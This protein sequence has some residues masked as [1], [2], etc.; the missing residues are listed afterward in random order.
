[1]RVKTDLKRDEIITCAAQVFRELGFERASMSEIAARMGGSKATL[2]GY[3]ASKEELFVTVTQA[4]A[5][6]HLEPAMVELQSGDVDI[7][8]ALRRFGQKVLAF[9]VQPEHV[10]VTRMVMG[11]SGRSDIGRRYYLNGPQRGL[12]FLTHYLREVMEKGILR[13]AEPY[14][15]AQHLLG[16]LECE[17]VPRRLFGAEPEPP[18][19]LIIS[20]AVAR[21]V[22]AFLAAYGAAGPGFAAS[23]PGAVAQ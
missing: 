12:E 7:R 14:F 15:M 20:E 8:T 3:F 18:T 23:S 6:A 16:L 11:E 4:E 22:D 2:Y 9:L 19:A 10:A 17:W 21:A 1:V 5:H 13:P